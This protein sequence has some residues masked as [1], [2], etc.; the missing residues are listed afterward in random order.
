MDLS[1]RVFGSNIDSKVKTYLKKQQEGTFN[2]KP[3]DP[4]SVSDEG[5]TYLGARTPYARMWTAVNVVDVQIDPN[6]KKKF[7][8][9]GDG[10]TIIHIV[11]DNRRT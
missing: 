7:K 8:T 3:G 11:N 9:I 1:K 6:N 10:Q 5:E 4:I 2:I